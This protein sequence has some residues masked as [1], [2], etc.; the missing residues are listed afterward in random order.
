MADIIQAWQRERK[1][2]VKLT[3]KRG[4][5]RLGRNTIPGL[6]SRWDEPGTSTLSHHNPSQQ[7]KGRQKGIGIF[8]L[9]DTR[10]LID[11]HIQILTTHLGWHRGPGCHH[12]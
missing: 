6:V 3:E 5:T 7:I 2:T 9:R 8:S 11:G 1:E 10:P 12:G 4:G